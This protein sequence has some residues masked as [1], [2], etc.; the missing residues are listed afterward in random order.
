MK[1]CVKTRDSERYCEHVSVLANTHTQQYCVT[2]LTAVVGST[3]LTVAYRELEA[4][5]A[6]VKRTRREEDKERRR[7]KGAP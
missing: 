5:T 7:R 2:G 3:A 4:P 1:V 6:G